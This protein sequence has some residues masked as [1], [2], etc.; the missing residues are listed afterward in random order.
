[1]IDLY[2]LLDQKLKSME[3]SLAQIKHERDTAALPTESASDQTRSVAEQLHTSLSRDYAKLV[4]LRHDLDNLPT[5]TDV[6]SLNS[7]V[8]L[9]HGNDKTIYLLV[10]EGL[11]GSREG[12]VALLAISTPLAQMILGKP[13]G[14]SFTFNQSKF[15]IV[16]IS[17]NL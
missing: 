15:V 5:S 10:P 11:G 13:I 2:R 9:S 1:M 14:F 12:G 3:Q 4:A 8:T 6:V 16:N 7:L 17:P